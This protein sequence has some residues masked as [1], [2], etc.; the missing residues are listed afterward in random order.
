MARVGLTTHVRL[1]RL[2]GLEAPHRRLD[3]GCQENVVREFSGNGGRLWPPGF[4]HLRFS[5]HPTANRRRLY[6]ISAGG[7]AGPGRGGQE[8][9]LSRGG[10]FARFGNLSSTI[11]STM[12]P[13]PKKPPRM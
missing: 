7:A 3:V 6:M 4:K 5:W 8:A 1:R 9:H 10:R 12:M 2:L 13:R 11:A